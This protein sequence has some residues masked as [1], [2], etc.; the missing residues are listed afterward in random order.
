MQVPRFWQGLE[1]HSLTFISHLG[2]VYPCTVDSQDQSCRVLVP[3]I[4]LGTVAAVGPVGV[5]T[6]P[7]MFAGRGGPGTLVNV[8]L[9]L[10]SGEAG[11]T[12]AGPLAR[13]LVGVA[14]SPGVAGVDQALVVQVADQPGLTLRTLALVAAHF[15]VAG[16]AVQTGGD[17]AVVLVLLAVLP[18]EPVDTD[19]LV[20]ALGVLAG[21]VV[22]AGIV[23]GALVHVLQ[24]VLTAPVVRTG[25][26]VGVDAVHTDSAILTEIATAVI[27]VDLTVL[28]TET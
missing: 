5:D 11:G 24:A 7:V 2:P 21:P 8:L 27:N 1:S 16:P 22:L 23:E 3:D 4:Y 25:T 6:D 12:G 28:S 14:P 26:V 19:A 17:G 18:D 10:L 15:V 20:A 9:A 13:H